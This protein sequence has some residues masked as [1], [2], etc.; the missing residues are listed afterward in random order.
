MR[1]KDILHRKRNSTQTAVIYKDQEYSYNDIYR[2]VVFHSQNLMN[3]G[4]HNV[5]IFIS[6]SANYVIAYF[7][8]AYMDRVVIPVDANSR[9]KQILSTIDYC[10]L[11]L[12]LTDDQ[13]Y[14]YLSGMVSK[15]P[16]QGIV[17]Y[18]VDSSE[19]SYFG[20]KGEER[21]KNRKVLEG[22]EDVAIMLHTSGTTSDPK[23]VM[24]THEN[25]ISNIE[26]NIASLALNSED[27]SLIVLP[28]CFGYCNTSQFLTHFYLGGSI[29]IYDG[30]F[31]PRRFLYYIEK[32]Q[33]SNSTCIPAMLYLLVK[34]NLKADHLSSFRYL[35]FGG[36]SI[37][38]EILARIIEM[39]P[40]TG[41][42]QTY[43][44][45]EA[46]PR[47][48]CLLSEDSRRKLGSIGKAI[49]GV[50]V[51]VFDEYDQEVPPGTEGEIVVRGKNVMK[52]YYKHP[53]ETDRV[54]INGWLHTG[55]IG[56]FDDEGYLYIVGRKKNVI[57]SGGLNIYP[58]EIE[59][60]LRTHPSVSE[61]Y[62]YPQEHE[63]LGEVPAARIVPYAK[64][65]LDVKGLYEYCKANLEI[66]KIPS[67]IEV[68]NHIEKTYNGKIRRVGNE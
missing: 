13:H 61:A 45:T 26:S 57:I 7:S 39:L 2:Q 4:N 37:S 53:D 66:Q 62:V 49:P 18:N 5:G 59:E 67:V 20:K 29:V 12:I 60:L 27:R 10:E 30:V 47:V 23:K 9:K 3:T 11:D 14:E 33:C 43:G 41:I 65:N 51:K 19:H 54:I 40:E 16:D 6:N 22:D 24:L 68:A 32:Y 52:G 63:L 8:V 21:K 42:V 1:I 55:D 25:L 35:C 38:E 36:G 58:E 31:I 34:S 56:R 64:E 44:Q 15:E 28:M 17:L 48:T 46:S 50:S